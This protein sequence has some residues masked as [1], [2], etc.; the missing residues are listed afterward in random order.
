M[1][2]SA[3]LAALLVVLFVLPAMPTGSVS[4]AAYPEPRPPSVH[5][6]HLYR[7]AELKTPPQGAV[8]TRP[9]IRQLMP[10]PRQRTPLYRNGQPS[11]HAPITLSRPAG[12]SLPNASR[13]RR[14]AVFPGMSF[15]QQVARLGSDQATEPPDTQLAAGPDSLV[16][17]TNASLSIWNKNGGLV[18]I[19]DLN[20]FFG[21]PTGFYFGDPR[22]IYDQQSGRY[23]LGGISLTSGERGAQSHTYLAVSQSSDPRSGWEIY[24]SQ[25]FDYLADQPKMAT[26]NDKVVVS[27]DDYGCAF[28]CP[29]VG[30]ETWVIQKSD[31]MAGLVARSWAFGPDNT[32]IGLVPS[33]ELAASDAAYLVYSSASVPSLPPHGWFIGVVTITGTPA[34]ADVQWTESDVAVELKSGPPAPVQP[35]RFGY[36]VTSQYDRLLSAVWSNGQLWMIGADGCKPIGD[37]DLRSCLR[38]IHLSGTHMPSLVLDADAGVTGDY[39]SF[40]A[41]TID[42]PGNVFVTYTESSPSLFG[43]AVGLAWPAGASAPSSA[44][45]LKPGAGIYDFNPCG[46]FNRWGDY[47]A[48][49]QDPL[50]PSDI[51]LA[52]EYMASSTNSCDWGTAIGRVTIDSTPPPRT[53]LPWWSRL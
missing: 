26:T 25:T 5:A 47:S 28:G 32:R 7:S 29:F 15:E 21:V 34:A 36:L 13:F 17:M 50:N 11:P 42:R 1:S 4:A 48:A 14:L 9:G 31:V 8:R 19:S 44:I 43:E 12:F 37:T 30:Q 33:V 49:A 45:L 23:F 24:R 22:A 51:W 3:R 40:P 16:E 35:G 38:L 20:T 2:S 41:L 39:L 10:D 53:R 18:S 6:G 27:W 46:W 52:A